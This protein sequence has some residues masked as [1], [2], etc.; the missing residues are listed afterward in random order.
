MSKPVYMKWS[1]QALPAPVLWIVLVSGIYAAMATLVGSAV[2]GGYILSTESVVPPLAGLI[3]GGVGAWGVAVGVIL[4]DVLHGTVGVLTLFQVAAAFLFAYIPGRLFDAT[5]ASIRDSVGG[6]TLA[7]C[8]FAVTAGATAAAATLGW[9]YELVAHAPFVTAGRLLIELLV[10]PAALGVPLFV[11]L[12]RVGAA[13]GRWPAE[14]RLGAIGGRRKAR[15]ASLQLA[16]AP[17]VWLVGG[18][19][20]NVGYGAF[21]AVVTEAPGALVD[22]GLGF[23]LP[24]YLPS[25]FGPDGARVQAAIGAVMFVVIATPMFRSMKQYVLAKQEV[26]SATDQA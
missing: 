11:L 1:V 4:T 23:L 15:P 5:E 13:S 26:L 7:R 8:L 19:V 24:M 9:G 2:V 14:V 21:E 18:I 25:V 22:R 3:L 6:A 17:P 12:R 10:L 16:V 20:W